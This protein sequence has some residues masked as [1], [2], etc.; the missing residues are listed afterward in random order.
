MNIPMGDVRPDC[1]RP[2]ILGVSLKLYFD[3]GTTIGWSRSVAAIAARHAALAT[4]AARLFVL[5]SLPAVPAA[6]REFAESPVGVGA[7]DLFWKEKG[8]YTGGVSGADLRAIGCRYAEIGHAERRSMFGESREIA[9]RKLAAA[10]RTGLTPVLC[11]GE[12]APED[13]EIAQRETL[14]ELEQVLALI[15]EKGE[16]DAGK[17]EPAR[18]LI[19]AYEP[20]WAIG[21]EAPAPAEHIRAVSNALRSHL[22]ADERIAD[23]AVIYGGSAGPGML[24]E[25]TGSIDGLFLGRFA[26]DPRTVERLLDEVAALPGPR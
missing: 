3:L 13:I 21:A 24:T 19:V 15:P 1:P 9:A 10:F 6:M 23:A 5:P 8:P 17:P 22:A 16:S 12:S 11:V 2:V 4:G 14:E 18:E 20:V 25:L 7:Q 26:H